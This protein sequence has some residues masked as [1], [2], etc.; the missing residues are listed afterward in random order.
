[1]EVYEINEN[2]VVMLEILFTRQS[3]HHIETSSLICRASQLIGCYMMETLAFN[4][5][6]MMSINKANTK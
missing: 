3:W 4:E 6:I 5:L 2:F 1:M